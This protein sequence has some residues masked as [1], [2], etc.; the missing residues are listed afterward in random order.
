MHTHGGAYL[1][2]VTLYTDAHMDARTHTYTGART[3]VQ[4]S[5]LDQFPRSGRG[6]TARVSDVFPGDF[7]ERVE[8]LLGLLQLTP[9][10][11]ISSQR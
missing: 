11:Y 3:R 4:P 2:I 7:Q 6:E 5:E 8:A 10:L 1:P 9:Y